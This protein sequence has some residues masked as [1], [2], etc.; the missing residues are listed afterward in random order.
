MKIDL[1]AACESLTRTRKTEDCVKM[2]TRGADVA[3]AEDQGMQKRP[4][5]RPTSDVCDG[6]R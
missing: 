2:S 3:V 1:P 6:K 4:R 5:S